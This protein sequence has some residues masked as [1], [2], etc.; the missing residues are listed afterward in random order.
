MLLNQSV[1][2]EIE[3]EDCVAAIFQVGRA[4]LSAMKISLLNPGFYQG[5]LF[6]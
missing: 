5:Q 6:T 3:L 2:L 1:N 4:S